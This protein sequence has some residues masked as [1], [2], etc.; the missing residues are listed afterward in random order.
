MKPAGTANI[1][2][3]VIWKQLLS[4]FFP[5]LMGSFFQQMYNT[6]DT[7]IVGR[8]IGTQA[9]AAVGSCT[10]LIYLV[11][12][13][14]I[15]LSSGAT[16]ILS[17]HYGAGNLQETERTLHTGFSLSLILGILTTAF[18]VGAGP[19]ILRLIRTP[20]NCMGDAVVYIRI[21]FSGA[22]ASMVYNMGTGILRAM[23]DS[24]RPTVFLIISCF[25]N[26]LLDLL[27]V[28][29]WKQGVAGAAAAT[30]LSQ[31]ISALLVTVCLCRLNPD[32]RL[33]WQKLLPDQKILLRV[34]A[35]G[36]PAGLQFI[37][38]DLS[39]I[40]TQA[41]V[42]SFGEATTAAWTA[43]TKSDAIIWMVMAAFGV[44][45]TTF[46]GQNFGAGKLE[47][48]HR[49]TRTCMA[50][51]AAATVILCALEVIF[52]KEI[53]SIYTPDPQVIAI[54]AGAMVY[55]V[56]F[57]VLFVPVEILGG[58]MRGTG[59][60]LVPTLI[61]GV[62]ACAFRIGWVLLVVSRHHILKTLVIC[63]PISW[64]MCSMVFFVVYFRG[65]W[66]T[67]QLHTAD[68]VA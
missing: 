33:R 11:N 20:E 34:L 45:I 47:R 32:F 66:L 29:V 56:P 39:N 54:G 3:G 57:C 68:K 46:V 62:F 36:I 16:V 23:G 37:T 60:S 64:L 27:F 55:T 38:Y 67:N 43:Y 52:R 49:G 2:E 15:G 63:Y 44:A 53:L 42:N 22:V 31:I 21:Y 65:H 28:V 48:I 9:L 59:Y 4:F 1:T 12:G 26:I 5:I 18:G 25:L 61:T 24:A 8:A 17:Q 51:S 6:V 40:M 30:V 7:I 41:S 19:W 10:S 14:F 58:T 35:I 13:F 50:M